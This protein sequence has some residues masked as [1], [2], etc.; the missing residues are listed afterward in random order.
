MGGDTVVDGY[1]VVGGGTVVVVHAVVKFRACHRNF[2]NVKH[3]H[4]VIKFCSSFFIRQIILILKEYSKRIKYF[5]AGQNPKC[6][7]KKRGT[8]FSLTLE[9]F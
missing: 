7:G 3:F 5:G 2:S 4:L 9:F 6:W 1:T 8:F